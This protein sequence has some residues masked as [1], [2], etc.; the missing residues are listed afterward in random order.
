MDLRF[1]MN[2]TANPG[3]MP[4]M[5]Y[6]QKVQKKEILPKFLLSFFRFIQQKWTE[7]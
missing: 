2:K 3:Q 7:N 4:E 1:R 5:S 6:V